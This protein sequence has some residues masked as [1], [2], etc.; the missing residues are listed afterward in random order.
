MKPSVT[1]AD[2]FRTAFP[3]YLRT[4]GKLPYEHYRI[5]NAIM[6]CRT[7]R[8]GARLYECSDCHGQQSHYHSCRNRHCP[9]CQG[10][11][12]LQWTQNRLDEMLPVGYFHAV[13]TVPAALNQFFLRNKRVL[14]TLLFR[15]V[16]HTLLKLAADP[17]RLG[18][19]IGFIAMAH[20][21]GQNL[22]D[23]PHIHC[24]IPA[25]GLKIGANRWKH[26]RKDFLFPAAVVKKLFKATFIAA[27]RAALADGSVQLH[28]KL[29]RF[30][31]PQPRKQL[32]HALYTQDWVVHIK[33]PFA[34]PH[35][36][37]RYL[38]NYVHRIALSEKRL[39]RFDG[40]RVTFSYTDYA[41]HNTRKLMSLPAVEFIRRFLL[42][43]VPRGFMRIRHYGFLA[44]KDRTAHINRCRKLLRQ[45]A[46]Q[47]SERN[48][49]ELILEALGYH[50]LLCPLCKAGILIPVQPGQRRLRLQT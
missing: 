43:A 27:F 13:F 7:P 6:N 9:H 20:S 29:Q 33:A 50:P 28:G 26:C 32:I 37:I 40:T 30:A 19:H 8:L 3:L 49:Y 31:D 24:I 17:R 41:D 22:M 25:G 10:Y 48:W 4:Y 16:S 39:V 42:H 1:L 11:R 36:V 5:A 44:N 2:I 46:L 21:W 15:A 35:H 18:A 45:R 47:R 12:N 14:Y 38:S 23:H 34:Q